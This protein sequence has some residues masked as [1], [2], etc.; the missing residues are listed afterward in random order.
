MILKNLQNL[1]NENNSFTKENRF[2][3]A[4]GD[5]NSNAGGG[6][7]DDKK[8]PNLDDLDQ[9]LEETRSSQEITDLYKLKDKISASDDLR[10][11]RESA[12]GQQD[13]ILT[14]F[15]E[16]MAGINELTSFEKYL[17]TA[18]KEIDRTGGWWLIPDDGAAI[19]KMSKFKEELAKI[20][21]VLGTD[22]P[23]ERMQNEAREIVKDLLSKTSTK[24]AK[25]EQAF[26]DEIDATALHKLDDIEEV[27]KK[28]A[29]HKLDA[30]KRDKIRFEGQIALLRKL[31]KCKSKKER[32]KL[33]NEAQPD[34][35]KHISTDPSQA[36]S[37]LKRKIEDVSDNK[38]ALSILKAFLLAE[39]I[40]SGD[41]EEI[42]G[43]L[44]MVMG[45]MIEDK[46][47][48]L[49]RANPDRKRRYE[50]RIEVLNKEIKDLTKDVR[51]SPEKLKLFL[52]RNSSIIF[53]EDY[54]VGMSEVEWK[55][56]KEEENYGDDIGMHLKLIDG[57]GNVLDEGKALAKDKEKAKKANPEDIRRRMGETKQK[58]DELQ[59]RI[60]API[61]K[62]RSRIQGEVKSKIESVFKDD[63]DGKKEQ[64]R[65]LGYD[66][67]GNI[68]DGVGILGT[69]KDWDNL[70]GTVTTG[71]D[72]ESGK[73][74]SA[75][76]DAKG[77]FN[78]PKDKEGFDLGI[79]DYLKIAAHP[80]ASDK[81]VRYALVSA[82]DMISAFER[83]L[84]E[85]E[86]I[87]VS[88]E[89]F[90]NKI[91]DFLS[92]IG[93]KISEKEVYRLRFISLYDF[94]HIGERLVEWTKDRYKRR[95]DRLIGD[96]G[97]AVFSGL[98]GPF[99]TLGNEFDRIKEQ[100]EKDMVEKYKTA[101]S[102]KDAWQ[103]MEVMYNTRNRDEMKACMYLL[104]DLGRIRWDDPK[105][106][107]QLMY[108]SHSAINFNINNP[109]TEVMHQGKLHKKL[110]K[111]V[112]VVW[113]YDTFQTWSSTNESSHNSKMERHTNFCHKTAEMPGGSIRFLKS[114]LAEYKEDKRNNRV[115]KV[116]PQLYEKMLHY[117]IKYGK[118]SG[119][120]KLYFLL[121]GIAC[122]L[123]PRDIA[124]RVNGEW[125]NDYPVIDIFGSKVE[126]S[127][128]PTME[129]IKK[130]A[131]IDGDI[132]EP[133]GAFKYWFQSYVLHLPRVYQRVNKALP[134][135]LPQDHDDATAWVGV[136]NAKTA[137][138]ILG[139]NATGYRM[140][141]TGYQNAT[142]GMLNYL[143]VLAENF[144][145][146]GEGET[147]GI[148]QL[149]RFATMHSVFDGIISGRMH[150][151]RPDFYRWTGNEY[152][153][154]RIVE[155]YTDVYGRA[156]VDGEKENGA[157][158]PKELVDIT[159]GYLLH[160][161][162]D[163]FGF[164]QNK[165]GTA[166][167]K[168][169]QAFVARM[170]STYNDNI[171]GKGKKEPGTV[172]ELHHATGEF[173]RSLF[174]TTKGRSNIKTMIEAIKKDHE[175]MEERMRKINPNFR[176]VADRTREAKQ[177]WNRKQMS[178]NQAA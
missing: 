98:P 56:V 135:G 155:G 166:T 40:K 10:G 34:E 47:I 169:I 57:I 133:G 36:V 127:E 4:D 122:G 141:P 110:R 111:A 162:P 33:I 165:S 105:L 104:A 161:E 69:L 58:A 176:N 167:P 31:R 145:N 138:S 109:D 1:L 39:G 120:S 72:S 5:G 15:N 92:N 164:I 73:D 118:G 108:F 70:A 91:D 61:S 14:K 55:Q 67:F 25:L 101:Y 38:E 124:S 50:V 147:G 99:A 103:V 20:T 112:G 77:D 94:K 74:L 83:K 59:K 100:S 9:L 107:S 81:T 35:S 46:T 24:K 158:T 106:W 149:T 12:D 117:D 154:P 157:T 150:S 90:N 125:I 28:S 26:I 173:L 6:A 65:A 63:L 126:G 128:K 18:L 88:I 41:S 37:E 85:P 153:K 22:L 11:V 177:N 172:E 86:D 93:D 78:L 16:R 123:L 140:P 144:E 132:N 168:E 8:D 152:E 60:K 137:E 136:M 64:F 80:G 89:S 68:M 7:D 131:E 146:M 151:G 143:D 79:S 42:A 129:H 21:G 163:Y 75:Y 32:I 130:W 3:H 49:G 29:S 160:L 114:M 19:D 174:Q 148:A 102:N 96:V 139:Q 30:A 87:I 17:Q 62:I 175:E 51:Q 171:F 170:K 84:A 95:S 13:T 76:F 159:K 178:K 156:K 115:P 52:L 71:I 116:D 119:E 48:R 53:D 82:E 113:D 2:V 44:E 121:Q 97:T 27:F 142:I 54:E 134:Q 43:V 66:E 45:S 23:R